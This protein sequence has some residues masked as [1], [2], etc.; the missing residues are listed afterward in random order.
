VNTAA[1]A[2]ARIINEGD[3]KALAAQL[4][5]IDRTLEIIAGQ[6]ASNSQWAQL[7]ADLNKMMQGRLTQKRKREFNHDLVMAASRYRKG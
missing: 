7:R 3:K 2:L 1:A 4:G 6:A 5:S